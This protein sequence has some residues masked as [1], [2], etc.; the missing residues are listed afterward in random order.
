MKEIYKTA[1]RAAVTPGWA[2][3]RALDLGANLSSSFFYPRNIKCVGNSIKRFDTTN[4]WNRTSE[5]KREAE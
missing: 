3:T 1:I 5:E 4:P 2:I